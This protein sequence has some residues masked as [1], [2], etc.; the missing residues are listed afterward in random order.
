MLESVAP[1]KALLSVNGYQIVVE[2]GDMNKKL[3]IQTRCCCPS[4]HL[5]L[6]FSFSL[7]DIWDLRV[8]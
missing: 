4:L 6:G 7:R 8:C 2:E 3:L 5:G 1:T